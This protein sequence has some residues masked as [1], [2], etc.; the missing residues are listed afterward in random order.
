MSLLTAFIEVDPAERPAITAALGAV[1]AAMR[2][3]DGCEDPSR[4]MSRR[5]SGSE[6]WQSRPMQIHLF[7]L[8]VALATLAQVAANIA[9]LVLAWRRVRP[10]SARAAMMLAV[11]ASIDLVWMTSCCVRSEGSGASMVWA[12]TQHAS[13]GDRLAMLDVLAI[14]APLVRSVQIIAFALAVRELSA[15][16]RP[17]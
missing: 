12:L 11:A 1:I 17:A 3:E 5:R 13:D 9:V 15:F 6:A 4:W 16:A 10:S 8:S 14:A 2:A 7:G